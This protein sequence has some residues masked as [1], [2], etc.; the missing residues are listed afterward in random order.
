MQ[1]YPDSDSI[2]LDKDNPPKTNKTGLPIMMSSF[3]KT[4]I[5]LQ[6]TPMTSC[7]EKQ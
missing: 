5:F 6:V 4:F 7:L 1:K 2:S 3:T